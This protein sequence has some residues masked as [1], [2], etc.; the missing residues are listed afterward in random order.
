MDFSIL[1]LSNLNENIMFHKNKEH[2]FEVIKKLDDLS[3]FVDLIGEDFD[4]LLEIEDSEIEMENGK[5]VLRSHEKRITLNGSIENW[6]VEGDY[7]SVED[8]I[9]C[10]FNGRDCRFIRMKTLNESNHIMI[11]VYDGG[12]THV[13]LST[14]IDD[15]CV[16]EVV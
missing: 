9:S 6:A 14:S 5:E 13:Y 12:D 8:Q 11:V 15:A 7:L 16:Y 1:L 4:G 2:S 10:S 3:Q